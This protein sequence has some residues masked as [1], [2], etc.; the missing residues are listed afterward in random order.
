MTFKY[1][2]LKKIGTQLYYNY[3]DIYSSHL[4]SDIASDNPDLAKVRWSKMY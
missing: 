2:E 4:P 3:P 1:A